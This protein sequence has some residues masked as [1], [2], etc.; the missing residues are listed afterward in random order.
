MSN[1]FPVTTNADDSDIMKGEKLPEP[2]KELNS[3]PHIQE[4]SILTI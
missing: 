2:I 4:A 1:C 3:E